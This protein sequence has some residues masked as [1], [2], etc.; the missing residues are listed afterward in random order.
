MKITLLHAL[1]L[2]CST[3]LAAAS[4]PVLA[5]GPDP[6]KTRELEAA[7]EE[8]ANAAR[9]VAELSRELG[10]N[11]KAMAIEQRT[12]VKP[13]LGVVLTTDSSAGARIAAVTPDGAAAEAGLRSGDRVVSVNGTAI[14][15]SDA[16]QR[17]SHARELLAEPSTDT[18]VLLGYER[19]GK[20]DS[21][22]IT[23]RPGRRLFAIGE[24]PDMRATG[25]RQFTLVRNGHGRVIDLDA[26]DFDFD[27]DRHG[28]DGLAA[29]IK[30]LAIAPEVRTEVIR[31][32]REACKDG[33]CVAPTV[34][35]AFRWNGLNLA[36][37]DQDLGRYFGTEAGVLVLGTGPLLDGL[38]AGDVIRKVDGKSVTTPRE[39][40]EALRGR[41]SGDKVA[42]EYLRD[43]K[44]ATAQITVPEPRVL[45]LPPMP[46]ASP[47]PPKPPKAP[48]APDAPPAPPSPPA[49]PL[50]LL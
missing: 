27:F 4:G 38:Q 46:P 49:P 24:I 8:L 3:A 2:A 45:N 32:S 6:A 41:A 10:I 26:P 47:A 37:V 25:N 40:M 15:G 43:R 44:P 34:M 31:L 12:N 9:R 20:R 5:A 39:A 7:R 42:V 17:L 30:E 16:G 11:A 13:M 14:G 35:E 19:D 22:R 29:G 21:V 48:S 36:S 28:L 23:P 18:P 50:A 1:A 33:K